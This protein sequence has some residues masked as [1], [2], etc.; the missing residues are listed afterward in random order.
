MVHSVETKVPEDNDPFFRN[1]DA[2]RKS[3]MKFVV[4]SSLPRARIVTL[5]SRVE[6]SS[7]MHEIEIGEDKIN[8]DPIELSVL[9]DEI[10][11][12]SGLSLLPPVGSSQHSTAGLSLLA[13]M[14]VGDIKRLQSKPRKQLILH[15]DQ[16]QVFS[17]TFPRPFFST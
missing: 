10:R 6:L 11:C 7:S 12:A 1:I 14:T 9:F 16:V 5:T 8:S 2:F 17:P 4:R 15:D 13:R 3:G